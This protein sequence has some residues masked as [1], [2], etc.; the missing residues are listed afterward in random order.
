ML[1]RPQSLRGL[2]AI[3]FALG[4]AIRAGA[5]L[6]SKSPFMP[7]AAAGAAAATAGAPLEYRGL[8]QTAQGL[9][10]RIVDPARHSGVWLLANE[11]DPG[12]DFVVNKSTSSTTP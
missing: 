9:K 7:P 3:G 6:P 4:G 2:L 5:Q 1:T 12:F 8:M 11:R 10:A